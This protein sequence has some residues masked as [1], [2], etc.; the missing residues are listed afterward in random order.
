[1]LSKSKKIAIA[2]GLAAAL[3]PLLI[4]LEDAIE[5][6]SRLVVILSAL[7]GTGCGPIPPANTSPMPSESIKYCEPACE[8]LESMKCDFAPPDCLSFCEDV[9]TGVY[10]PTFNAVCVSEA[11]SCEEAGGCQ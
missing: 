10:F 3:I 2:S 7:L 8:N 4:W 9:N 1:M 11:K 6:F 5:L